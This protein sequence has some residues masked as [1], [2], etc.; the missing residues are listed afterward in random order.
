MHHLYRHFSTSGELLYVG[1]SLHAVTRL[2]QHKS[3]APWFDSVASVTMDAFETKSEAAEAERRAIASEKPRF[4]VVGTVCPHAA[5][6]TKPL[7]TSMMTAETFRATLKSL[8]IPQKKFAKLTGYR[9]ETVSRW[10]CGRADIPLTIEVIV[11]HM[12]ERAELV[13]QPQTT[14]KAL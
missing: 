2:P 1:I 10:A 8:D 11:E 4:N 13:G 5:R 14:V 3:S 7:R 12:L 9:K 6:Y